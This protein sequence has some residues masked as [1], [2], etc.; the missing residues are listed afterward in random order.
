MS[1]R[2]SFW[3]RA[4]ACAAPAAL[5]ASARTDGVEERAPCPAVGP[6]A[7]DVDVFQRKTSPAQWSIGDP[8]AEEQ[9]LLELMNRA[10]MH[11]AD[12]G[13][14]IFVDYGSA[15]VKQATDYFLAQ[16]PGVEFTR[17]ENR[18]AFHGY[19]A[20]PPLAFS[21]KLID[22]ARGHSALLKQYDQQ[23]HQISDGNGDPL[24]GP[25]GV[26]VE[27]DLRGRVVA[28]G[29]A[30]TNLGENVFSY[31]SDM[32]HAHAG[33]AVDFGQPVPVGETR[34]YLGHRLNLMDFD[35][36]PSRGFVEVGV[37]VVSDDDPATTV[38]PRIVTIDFAVPAADPTTF[39][40]GVVY[41]DLN[42]NGFYDIG[43]GL[44][45]VR[46]DLDVGGAYAVTSTSGGYAVPVY[47]A[48]GTVHVT[49]TGQPGTP[50][51]V[52]GT[53]TVAVDVTTANVKADFNRPPDPPL[54]PWASVV[55]SGL[56]QTVTD[57]APAIA[58]IDFPE[59]A[60]FSDLVGDVAVAV[61][62]DHPAREELTATLTSPDGASVVLFLR[63]AP[64]AGLRGEFDASLKPAEPLDGFV[65]RSYVGPW[66]L[67]IDDAAPGND[68]VLTDWRIRVRPQW[69]RP[70]FADASS[71]V[72]SKFALID[73]KRPAADTLV[74]KAVVDAGPVPL[75]VVRDPLLRIRELGGAGAI[76][77]S[78]PLTR[79]SVKR[80]VRGTSKTTVS[81]TV[82]KLDLPDLSAHPIVA[83][84]L[85][86]DDA[87]VTQTV[88][89]SKG[90][91]NGAPANVTSPLFHVD[92]LTTRVVKGVSD[93]TV[94]GRLASNGPL[95]GAGTL[96]VF[97]GPVHL[98]DSM[99]N[100]SLKGSATTFKGRGPVKS[101]S[102]DAV[103]GT[104]AL[105][106]AATGEVRSMDG[107]IDVALRLGDDG[108]FGKTSIVPAGG[109]ASS[110]K[111]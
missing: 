110:L 62:I 104:F 75:G 55:S 15:R 111:Y 108:F 105:V 28:A 60:G 67:R 81:A 79:A 80:A 23:S 36:D 90:A 63:G 89:L 74:F 7:G 106:V 17:A 1:P 14:R 26:P 73:S 42:G 27:P 101:L 99:A 5:F 30:G 32:V 84:E 69:T 52:I 64:G 88:R 21:A 10:R 96:D 2:V 72:V 94:K 11:P 109:S 65:G 77:F 43:E 107:S 25:G 56:T 98:R 12:E 57:V 54:P 40:T 78:T 82:R 24:L 20:K 49:A 47:G 18:D 44:G 19:A 100:A 66:T 85:S 33:F 61:A 45:G 9:L 6:V 34:P 41:D 92:S 97:F 8:T 53:Q 93:Y 87:I 35:G 29:Y 58:T 51:A 38:G 48:P 71:L 59:Q 31:A 91:F 39:V 76:Y 83:L 68:G 3:I 95:V 86:L 70:L 102:V 50:G 103:K 13:D 46:I 16:R 37:G 22:S 4:A